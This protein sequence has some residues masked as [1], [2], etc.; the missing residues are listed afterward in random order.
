MA[1]DDI[2]T[3]IITGKTE[4]QMVSE[5]KSTSFCEAEGISMPT[6]MTC[7]LCK[8]PAGS[9]SVRLHEDSD[10]V[11]IA[12]MKLNKYEVEMSSGVFFQYHLCDECMVLL[13]D[14]AE[15]ADVG[16]E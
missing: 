5:I 9:K 16:A 2:K 8:R 4:D 14:F 7:Y 12:A 15:Q 13:Q 11:N 3:F 1:E 6:H 10:N